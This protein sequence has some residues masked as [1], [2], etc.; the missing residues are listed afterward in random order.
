[1][2]RSVWN[3]W[4]YAT[5]KHL[6]SPVGPFHGNLPRQITNEVTVTQTGIE[7][8][9]RFHCSIYDRHTTRIRTGQRCRRR[10]LP[11]RIRHCATIARSTGHSTKP[12]RRTSDTSR[13]KQRPT[14]REATNP[15]HHRLHLLR[16]VCRKTSAVHSSSITTT[17]VP[18]RQQSVPP[19]HQGNGKTGRSAFRVARR[20]EGLPNLG[21]GLPSLPTSKVSRH[22]VTPLGDFTPPPA[23]FLHIHIDL[24]G[25]LPTSAGYTYCLTAVDR[26]TRWPEAI[27]IPD[28]TA[29]TVAH[30]LFTGWISR[31]GCPENITSDQGRQFEPQL[32]HSLAKLC[33]IKLS[34]TTA[35]H[36]AANTLVERFHRTLKTAI[37]CHAYRHWTEAL[38]L[39]HVPSYTRTSQTAHTSASDTIQLVGPYQVLSR[40]DKTLKLLVRWKS[41]IESVDR[42][43]PAH[44]FNE[45]CGHTTSKPAASATPSTTPS[46]ISTC[47]SKTKTPRS[48]PHVHLPVHFSP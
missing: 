22:T 35:Y 10:S 28:I 7:A 3:L 6:Y 32:F 27:P 13:C 18:V 17:S 15:R 41:I 34:R 23:R 8:T 37:V 30:A 11:L 5:R 12:R 42:V 44:I 2:F 14:A 26:F 39:V 38:P 36:S 19:R 40:K 16:F 43:K 1:M 29:E 24:V 9:P 46:D 25:P 45:D 21:T 20:T 47:P 33:G 48:G 31:F 4:L